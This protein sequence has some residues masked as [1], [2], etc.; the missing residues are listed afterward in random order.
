MLHLWIGR[1]YFAFW[2]CVL[3]WGGHIVELLEWGLALSVERI[4]YMFY[5][6]T[7]S[8]HLPVIFSITYFFIIIFQGLG[9]LVVCFS[10]STITRISPF[11]FRFYPAIVSLAG[12][13][14]PL[15]P[16]PWFGLAGL[17]PTISFVFHPEWLQ[18][19]L[20]LP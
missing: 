16:F 5:H 4:H 8:I 17:L 7:S 10:P 19:Q 13:C 18:G 1:T 2:S 20:S 12:E 14:H 11:F 15:T 6:S 9:I 3:S